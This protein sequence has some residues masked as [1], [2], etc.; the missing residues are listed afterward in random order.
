MTRTKQSHN[1]LMS[2]ETMQ[3]NADLTRVV[4]LQILT[5]S[6]LA[7]QSWTGDHEHLTEASINDKWNQNEVSDVPAER[8]FKSSSCLSVDLSLDSTSAGQTF[9]Y[10]HFTASSY[11]REGDLKPR[12]ALKRVWVAI[13][14]VASKKTRMVVTRMAY[15]KH[16]G[17]HCHRNV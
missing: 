12:K 14:L 17:G 6:Q 3:L 2:E 11:F 1:P 16:L 9:C 4:G 5:D 7:L 13:M 15:T 10:L 8:V